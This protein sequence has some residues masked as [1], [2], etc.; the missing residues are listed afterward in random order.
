MKWALFSLLTLSLSQHSLAFSPEEAQGLL[1]IHNQWP[2]KKLLKDKDLC[3]F[4]NQLVNDAKPKF[5]HQEL[6]CSFRVQDKND[7]DAGD[8]SL[9]LQERNINLT[10][11]QVSNIMNLKHPDSTAMTGKEVADEAVKRMKE[12]FGF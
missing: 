8:K 4:H 3:D 12:D 6:D 9:R 7:T 5:K 10:V 1:E 2:T 11:S